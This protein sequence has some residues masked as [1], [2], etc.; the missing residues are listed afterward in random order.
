MTRLRT[1]LPA[2]VA[3]LA[4]P[5]PAA[6]PVR[7]NRDVR[8]ILAENCFGCHGAGKQKGG[9][10]LGRF[11]AAAAKNKKSDVFAVVPK[12]PGESEAVKRILSTDAKEVMP[13]ADS[14]KK[15]TDAQK[16]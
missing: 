2:V 14:H 9:L 7:F 1:V 15:L 5:A 3:L 11:E 13:P 16:A 12:K 10:R 4:G 6:E 8:P